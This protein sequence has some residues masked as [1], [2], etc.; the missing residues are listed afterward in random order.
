MNKATTGILLLA[1]LVLIVGCGRSDPEADAPDV[2]VFAAAS[3]TDAV[4]RVACRFEKQQGITVRTNFAATSTL[5]QQVTNGAGADVFISAD[6]AWADRL[7]RNGLVARRCDLLGNQIVIIVAADCPVEVTRAEDLLDPRITHVAIADPHAVPAGIYAREAL[8]KLGLWEQLSPKAVASSN[9]RQA[10]DYV[11]TGAAEAGIVYATD[12]V[13]ARSAV[14]RVELDADLTEPIRYPLLL[15]KEAEGNADAE[16]LYA[17][18]QESE[19]AEVFRQH[20]FR[21]LDETVASDASRRYPAAKQR[22]TFFLL[23]S[24]EWVALRLSFQVAV[25]AA[26]AGLPIALAVAYLLAR[27]S[28]PGKWVLEAVVNAP[29]VLPPVVTGY[30]LLILLAPRGPIGSVLGDVFG[31]KIVFT[32]WAAVVASAVVSFPLMVRAIRLAFEAIDPR[33]EMAARSLGASRLATFF[34]VTLPLARRGVI[35]GWMLAFARSLGEFGATIMVAGNI[36]GYTNTIPLQIYSMSSEPGGMGQCWRLVVLSIILA[37][38]ALAVSELLARR[39][40]RHES[41]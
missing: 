8:Q 16:A 23:S 34:S 2:V 7:E 31:V 22:P 28:F 39:Q 38:G 30:L 40:N 1:P 17:Y 6:R 19:A 24:A 13:L 32:W 37:C 4:K 27:A 18:F 33:L 26:L 10:L 3:T 9:V 35:A 12:A 5:A 36:E 21:V 14:V 15:M 11:E 20:G 41:A 29:L 25:C